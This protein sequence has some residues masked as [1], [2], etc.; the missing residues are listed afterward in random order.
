MYS[1]HKKQLNHAKILHV[2][3]R[4]AFSAMFLRSVSLCNHGLAK[5]RGVIVQIGGTYPDGFKNSDGDD[6]S[7]EKIGGDF[8]LVD[9]GEDIGLKM[10]A[11]FNLAKVFS[12]PFAEAPHMGK[13][14]TV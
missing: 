12:V 9:W 4:V 7:G 11:K 13:T 14:H 5:L 3:D 10:I 1:A 8:A 6:V 2:G